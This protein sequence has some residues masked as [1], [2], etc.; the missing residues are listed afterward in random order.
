ME[1]MAENRYRCDRRYAFF[2]VFM[3]FRAGPHHIPKLPRSRKPIPISRNQ[4]LQITMNTVTSVRRFRSVYR[5]VGGMGC[6]LVRVVIIGS[7][8]SDAMMPS[9]ITVLTM[10]GWKKTE[11]S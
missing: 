4:T 6:R 11:I 9:G 7:A 10:I 3:V 8:R 2:E 5:P 1:A